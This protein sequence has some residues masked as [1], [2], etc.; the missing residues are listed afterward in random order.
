MSENSATRSS[1]LTD[2]AP[3]ALALFGFTLALYGVRYAAGVEVTVGLNYALLVSGVA[4][5]VCG[6]LC[7]VKGLAYPGYVLGTFGFWVVGLFLLLTSGVGAPGFTPDAIAWYVLVMVVPTVYLAIPAFVYRNLPFMVA[8]T[9]ITA[10]I[11]SLGFGTMVG[12]ATLTRASGWLALLGAVAIWYVGAGDILR[13]CG[14]LSA[15]G[16]APAAEEPAPY[17]VAAAS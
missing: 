11:L 1:S 4:E 15:K 13:N 10:L 3:I 9:A 16:T 8:F 5:I 2:A 14:V 17:T 7:L 12:S 6:V